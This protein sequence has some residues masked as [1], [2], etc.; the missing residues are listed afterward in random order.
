MVKVLPDTAFPTNSAYLEV[1]PSLMVNTWASSSLMT[2]RRSPDDQYQEKPECAP[3][4]VSGSLSGIVTRMV[5]RSC[6][7]CGAGSSRTISRVQER[8]ARLSSNAAKRL[9]C[10]ISGLVYW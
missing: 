2:V 10:F 9:C 4:L 6:E 5:T 7:S 8:A 1:K 3:T